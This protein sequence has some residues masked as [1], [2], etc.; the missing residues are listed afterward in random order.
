MNKLLWISGFIFVALFSKTHANQELI[1]NQVFHHAPSAIK[2]IDGTHIYLNS[3]RVVLY[4]SKIYLL[5]D[6]G[7][8][9][10]IPNIH[11]DQAGLYLSSKSGMTKIYICRTCTKKYYYNPRTCSQCYGKNFDV[12]WEI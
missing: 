8:P 4:D 10:S 5:D 11:S 7:N 2:R 3:E 1:I 9:L 6:S 12:R